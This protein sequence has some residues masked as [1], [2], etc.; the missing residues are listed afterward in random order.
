[1]DNFSRF[2]A[3]GTPLTEEEIAN[4][5]AVRAAGCECDPLPLLGCIPNLGPRCRL[6]NV[7]GYT[8]NED[9]G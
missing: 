2:W 3:D 1:M 5:K 6:C 9:N 8:E 7:D 4:V